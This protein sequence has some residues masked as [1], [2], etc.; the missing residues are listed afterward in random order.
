MICDCS[1]TASDFVFFFQA[2]DGIRDVA[3]TG[4]QTCALPISTGSDS[5]AKKPDSAISR[6]G[7]FGA[8]AR[9]HVLATKKITRSE[10]RRVGKECRSRGTPHHEKKKIKTRM[11]DTNNIHQEHNR[12]EDRE[13]G[14]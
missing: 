6:F 3:V 14:A 2:E 9:V 11:R 13:T 12:F 1:A 8:A 5:G 10:E 7:T 4:V